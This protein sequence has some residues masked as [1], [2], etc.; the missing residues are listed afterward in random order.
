MVALEGKIYYDAELYQSL[1]DAILS[2]LA[3]GDRFTIPEARE[4]TELSRKYM[5][6]LLNKM[7]LD[8]WVRRDENDRIVMK[9]PQSQDKAA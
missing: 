7:E 9:C 5:I 1:I 2:G 3:E 6:P 8:R 4:R